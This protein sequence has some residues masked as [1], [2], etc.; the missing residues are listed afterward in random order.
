MQAENETIVNPF[1]MASLDQIQAG[2]RK[3]RAELLAALEPEALKAGADAAALVE[4]RIV[5]K[6]ETHSGKRLSAYS[7]AEVPAFFFLGR[8]RNTRGENAIKRKAKKREPVSYREFR[9]LNGLNVTHKN[10]EFTGE[11]WQGFGVTG[12]QTLQ[13]GVVVVSIGGKN[14]RTRTLLGY[15]SEREQTQIT[16]PSQQEIRAISAGV[17]ARLVEIIKRHV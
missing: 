4:N 9:Q 15:H 13:P 16:Q 3:A 7:E 17:S 1:I 8:S 14:E 6:G 12:V 11:M 2:I 10:L 5:S